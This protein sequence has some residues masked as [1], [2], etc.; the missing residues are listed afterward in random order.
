MSNTSDEGLQSA[1]G[2]T[3]EECERL[4]DEA[5][6]AWEAIRRI[7]GKGILPRTR[8]ELM[9]LVEEPLQEACGILYDLNIQTL[10]SSCNI[11]DWTRGTAGLVISWDSLSESNRRIAS[12]I[13]S[14]E[15]TPFTEDPEG[16]AG[17]FIFLPIGRFDTPAMIGAQAAEIASRF[18]SQPMTWAPTWT[19]EEIRQTWYFEGRRVTDIPESDLI[20]ILHTYDYFVGPDQTVWASEEHFRKTATQEA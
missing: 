11:L 1:T 7:S 15:I 3:S 5:L 8:A 16:L 17:V 19:L 18:E 14:V 6:G 4:E 20:M 10:G 2:R 13:P 9:D 12:E